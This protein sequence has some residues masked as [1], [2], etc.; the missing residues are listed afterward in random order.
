MTEGEIDRPHQQAAKPADAAYLLAM[1]ASMFGQYVIGSR[2]VVPG[3]ASATAQ[4]ILGHETLFRMAV[5]SSLLVLAPNVTLITSLYTVLKRVHEGLAVFAT[6]LRLER[7]SGGRSHS[8]QAMTWHNGPNVDVG[9]IV[10]EGGGHGI[11]QPYRRHP[12]LLGPSPK[13]PNGPELIWAFFDRQ[14]R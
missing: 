6:F 4:N 8:R 2:L 1:A 11:P 10:I 7:D 5:T 12:R 9:L 14:R 13:E 3:D